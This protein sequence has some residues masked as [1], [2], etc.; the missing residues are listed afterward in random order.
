[1]SALEYLE[2]ASVEKTAKEF[3]TYKILNVFGNGE[4]KKK[5]ENL[6]AAGE[7]GRN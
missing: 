1:M 2:F 6:K 5:L 4:S 7:S 3:G